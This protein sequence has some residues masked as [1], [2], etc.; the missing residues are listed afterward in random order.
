MRGLLV[1]DFR[2]V[3][4]SKKML[5]MLLVIE[6]VF[7]VMQG[8][9]SLPYVTG[10][11]MIGCGMLSL[12]AITSDEYTKSMAF[13]MAM[14]VRRQDY[15]LEKYLFSL[16]CTLV[17]FFISVI[18]CCLLRPGRLM[19]TLGTAA[20]ILAVMIMLQMAMLPAQLKYGGER[21]R[22]VLVG[23]FAVA[24][25]C[26]SWIKKVGGKHPGMMEGLLKAVQHMVDGW[27]KLGRFSM[28]ICV[29]AL[30]GACFLLSLAVSRRIIEKKEF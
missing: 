3:M 7:L 30:C 16:F 9:D 18:P 21:G 1:K 20:V 28:W 29:A 23:I 11:M 26:F 8:A 5:A 15:V 17:G 27:K 10:Y 4:K 13:L 2:F 14:P 12:S 19:E 22:I 6:T 24:V 25:L